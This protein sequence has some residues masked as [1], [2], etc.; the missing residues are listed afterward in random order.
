MS[1]QKAPQSALFRK[2]GAPV[3]EG[4][5][6]AHLR[7][8]ERGRNSPEPEHTHSQ[9]QCMWAPPPRTVPFVDGRWTSVC[10]ERAS[11]GVNPQASKP[12]R[13]GI[14]PSWSVTSLLPLSVRV[15]KL[16]H[17]A[18]GVVDGY[19]A[20]LTQTLP[21]E[22]RAEGSDLVLLVLLLLGKLH[23]NL[24]GREERNVTLALLLKKMKR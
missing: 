19:W 18:V 12:G 22:R 7:P 16:V 21:L 13:S 23:K 9:S 11:A 4:Y 24:P 6:H 15:S 1:H 2:H 14:G 3:D 5:T 17:D 20:V 10:V 8:R